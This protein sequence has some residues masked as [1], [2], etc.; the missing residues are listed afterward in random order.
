M[1][2]RRAIILL[3]GY[4][5]STS[6][7]LGETPYYELSRE[8]VVTRADQGD[9]DCQALLAQWY[10]RGEMTPGAPPDMSK[11]RH[12]AELS[13]AQNNSLGQNILA[14]YHLQTPEQEER[15]KSLCIIAAAGLERRATEGDAKAQLELGKLRGSSLAGEKDYAK[16]AELIRQSAE[17]GYVEA[18]SYLAALHEGGSDNPH[19]ERNHLEAIALYEKINAYGAIGAILARHATTP[20]E[21]DAAIVAYKKS[22]ENSS[23]ELARLQTRLSIRQC[24]VAAANPNDDEAK[25]RDEELMRLYSEVQQIMMMQMMEQSLTEPE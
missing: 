21:Y 18:V 17:S 10:A 24:E 23:S 3:A 2:I 5:L 14:V 4:L 16:S 20:Q 12:Y 15:C 13:A 11:S 22:L 19:I 7:T 25:Y 8:D 1:A 9:G 6:I